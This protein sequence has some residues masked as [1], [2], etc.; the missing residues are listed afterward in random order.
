MKALI[1]EDELIIAHALGSMLLDMSFTEV[2]MEPVKEKAIAL[3]TESFDLVLLDIHLGKGGEGFELG[4]LCRQKGIPFLYTT[5]YTDKST[6]DRAIQTNP[7]AYLVKPV[8]ETNLYAA[9]QIVLSQQ[10]TRHDPILEFKDGNTLI[11]LAVSEVL[12]LKSENI[13]VQVVTD[14]V[15]YMNRGSLTSLIQKVPDGFLIQTHRAFAIN[16]RRVKKVSSSF[17]TIGEV[18][19]PLSRNF[20]KQAGF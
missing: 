14:K 13:Y 5:S 1:V 19:I 10:R 7:G 3:L 17:V 16:P 20:K 18:D 4:E 6:L 2:L 8:T 12:Y 9:V 11:R 15:T